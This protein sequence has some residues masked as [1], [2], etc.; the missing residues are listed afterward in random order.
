LRQRIGVH[1]AKELA[2]TAKMLTGE[3]A[4]AIGLVNAVVAADALDAAVD[5]VVGDIVDG[6]PMALAITKRELDNATSSL[7]QALEAEALGQSLNAQSE[8]L[9]EA[10]VA[11]AERRPPVFKGR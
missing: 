6:P 4:M 7:A 3:E 11:Y 2:F 9:R 8:D 10:L 1:K 5:G